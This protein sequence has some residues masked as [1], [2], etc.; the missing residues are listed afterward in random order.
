MKDDILAFN[1]KQ[2]FEAIE[3]KQ[4]EACQMQAVQWQKTAH[5]HHGRRWHS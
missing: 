2:V 5:I 4:P 1:K 3:K